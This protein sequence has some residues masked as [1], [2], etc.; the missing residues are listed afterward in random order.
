MNITNQ[1]RIGLLVDQLRLQTESWLAELDDCIDDIKVAYRKNWMP[2]RLAGYSEEVYSTEEEQSLPDVIKKLFLDIIDSLDEIKGMS[3]DGK[4][5]LTIRLEKL[6]LEYLDSI[7]EMF[8]YHPDII[9]WFNASNFTG[10][11]DGYRSIK[12]LRKFANIEENIILIGSNGCGK[13]TL[14][15]ILKGND[16]ETIT[17]IPAQKSLFFTTEKEALS[18]RVSDVREELLKNEIE[19][20]KSE[21]D[22]S[23]TEYQKFQFTKLLIA[24][25]E[26]YFEFLRDCREAGKDSTT[27]QCIYD[28]VRSIFKTV[29]KDIDILFSESFD[30]SIYCK[31]GDQEY[32]LNGLSEGEKVALYYSMSV[33]M[34][35][36]NSFIVVDE[37]ET[38]LNPSLANTIWNKLVC[39][40]VDCQFIFITHSVNFVLSK[41]NYKT[42][43]IKNYSYPDQFSF[44]MIGDSYLLPKQLMTEILGS[45][46]PIVF[47]EGDDK[48]SLDYQVYN[49]L[50]Q[51]KYTVLPVGGHKAVIDNCRVLNEATWIGIEAKGI[52]DG[53]LRDKEQIESLY[54]NGIVVLP[55]NEIEMLLLSNPVMESTIKGSHPCNYKAIIDNFEEE[56]FKHVEK[57]LERIVLDKTRLVVNGILENWRIDSFKTIGEIKDNLVNLQDIDVDGIYADTKQTL[58]SIVN[59]R[60]YN[61]LLRVCNLK[62]EISKGLANKYLDAEYE[63]KAVEHIAMEND[64]KDLLLQMFI[65]DFI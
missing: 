18:S 6:T 45:K 48:N 53:D 33:L 42:I 3:F 12:L 54:S 47:C 60:D 31:R 27:G 40:R 9:S 63:S 62:T 61:Q 57:N 49:S 20:S 24:M 26:N 7:S 52:I 1:K 11:L 34:A 44:E 55:F 46:N 10:W 39:E 16:F 8:S 4:G 65:P 14:A 29:F 51:D 23:F 36:N 50:L 32:P 58:E 13:S 43:W 30:K 28:K 17:V 5:S 35:P 15:Q 41:N 2:E 19:V 25:R 22:Y 56:F 59:S 37:P 64:L 38:F 21:E